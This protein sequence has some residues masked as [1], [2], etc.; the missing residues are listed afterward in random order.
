MEKRLQTFLCLC[1]CLTFHLTYN[2]CR[3]KELLRIQIVKPLSAFLLDFKKYKIIKCR[4]RII[5]RDWINI[6]SQVQ[7]LPFPSERKSSSEGRANAKKIL[8]FLP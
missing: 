6:V 8:Y 1:Y 5:L 7:F 4:L 3:K 2:R